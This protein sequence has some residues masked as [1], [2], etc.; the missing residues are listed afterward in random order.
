MC[1]GSLNRQLTPAPDTRVYNGQRPSGVKCVRHTVARRAPAPASPSPAGFPRTP[2][3]RS[4]RGCA[5]LS[6]L[7][8]ALALLLGVPDLT[9]RRARKTPAGWKAE[10]D[11][12]EWRSLCRA[13]DFV[14]VGQI[15]WTAHML[16]VER[17]VAK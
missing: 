5:R 11:N 15:V 10:A 6:R 8:P 16:D 3:P 4:G 7:L 13:E 12:R 17:A 14:V 9:V 2:D 1:L